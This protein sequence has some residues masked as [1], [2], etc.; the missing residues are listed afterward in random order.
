MA[1]LRDIKMEKNSSEPQDLIS[2]PICLGGTSLAEL[3]HPSK[4]LWGGSCLPCQADP[5]AAL[6]PI[7]GLSLR[8]GRQC[9]VEGHLPESN[10]ANLQ[11]SVQVRVPLP[12]TGRGCASVGR[13]GWEGVCSPM[14]CQPRGVPAL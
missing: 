10:Q 6:P 14:G 12:G 1:G 4:E 9:L 3:Q 2:H 7:P 8:P 5:P 13:T 11:G